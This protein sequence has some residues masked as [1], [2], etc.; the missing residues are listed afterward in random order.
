MTPVMTMAPIDNS[1][2]QSSIHNTNEEQKEVPP[3]RK[4]TITLTAAGDI[5][6]HNTLIWSGEQA[7]GSY[8]FD[9]F[10]PIKSLIEEGDYA[11]T[12][13][14]A[15]LAGPSSGYTGYP[16]F[17]SPD[18]VATTLKKS[19]FDL[20]VTANNHVLDR[21]FQGAIRSLEVLRNAGVDTLGTYKNNHESETLLIKDI[22]GVKVGYLAYTYGTNGLHI[23]QDSPYLVKLFDRS[24]I[25]ND[26]ALMR[27]QV[28]VLVLIL[29]W[30]VE[31]SPQPSDEQKKMARE[32]VEAGAD[33]ILG[34]HPHVIEPM[35]V[36][37]V[38]D[39]NKFIIYSMGN[40]VGDQ[41]GIERNS[42]IV[43]KLKFT[44]DFST[45]RISLD[46]ATYI[47]TYSHAYNEQ[48]KRKFRVVPIEQTIQ[49]IKENRDPYLTG[50]DIPVLEQ[51]LHQTEK[52]L[53]EGF[54]SE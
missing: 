4:E 37:K 49:A 48:G 7:N 14:E 47:P 15:A 30:G 5:L 26:I 8:N 29:H 28:D 12:N 1:V 21:G 40:I 45:G 13:L 35:E 16:Q 20:V 38:G 19:G 39:Q 52:Q 54:H 11:S 27:P 9:F 22:R 6:M 41:H 24:K 50:A 23:P 46:E 34:S 44:K 17:N 33:V 2:A 42:G 51:A 10:A 43:L 53:G 25:L 36:L 18:E 32:F 3:P 31:Y